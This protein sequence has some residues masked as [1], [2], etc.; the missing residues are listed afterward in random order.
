ME[1]SENA[2]PPLEGR[3]GTGLHRLDPDR[4]AEI[5]AG[6]KHA[7]G[8]TRLELMLHTVFARLVADPSAGMRSPRP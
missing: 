8:S 6:L 1:A 7:A 4:V 3:G 2:G 5:L